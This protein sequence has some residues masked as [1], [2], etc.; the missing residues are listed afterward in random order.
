MKKYGTDSTHLKLTGK[1]LDGY[2]LAGD[3]TIIERDDVQD[4][5]VDGETYGAEHVYSYDVKS[6]DG[7]TH[8]DTEAEL[9]AQLEEYADLFRVDEED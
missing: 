1:A 4:Y 9:I 2:T 8:Y 6:L 7:T 3:I 5:I